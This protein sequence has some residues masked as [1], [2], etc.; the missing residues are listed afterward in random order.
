MTMGKALTYGSLI[1]AVLFAGCGL[2][3]D[4]SVDVE[5]RTDSDTYV[6]SPGGHVALTVANRGNDPLYIPCEGVVYLQE[7]EQG[8]V[9]NS[10]T[11]AGTETC[12]W[13]VLE[14]G[15]STRREYLFD[16]DYKLSGLDDT[17]DA[18]YDES[19]RY[20]FRFK[21][22]RKSGGHEI[23]KELELSNLFTMVKQQERTTS[24]LQRIR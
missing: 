7:L 22:Y 4:D 15:Q 13:Q 17:S 14:P 5:I 2:L 1:L 19:V 9:T 10:W 18:M 12:G 3:T 11:I 8:R 24:P 21:L 16:E 23:D 6:A 20:R